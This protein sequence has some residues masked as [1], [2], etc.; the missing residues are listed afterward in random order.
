MRLRL[1][2]V[3]LGRIKGSSSEVSA[4]SGLSTTARREGRL[5]GSFRCIVASGAGKNGPQTSYSSGADHNMR[6]R[7]GLS[8]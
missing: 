6:V 3:S 5:A 8:Y 1:V 4:R 7:V 2:P